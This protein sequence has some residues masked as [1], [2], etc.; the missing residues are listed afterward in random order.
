MTTILIEILAQSLI[1]DQLKKVELP[2]Q[3]INDGFYSFNIDSKVIYS[4]YEVNKRYYLCEDI[5]LDNNA[6]EKN[7]IAQLKKIVL[8]FLNSIKR[9]G[10]QHHIIQVQLGESKNYAEYPVLRDITNVLFNFEE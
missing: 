1:T 3:T 9:F 4:E 10:H 2:S 7:K 8:N 5:Y 6:L